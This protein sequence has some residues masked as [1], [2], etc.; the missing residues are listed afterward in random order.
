MTLSVIIPAYNEEKYLPGCLESLVKF[1]GGKFLEIIVV[2]NA[3]RDRTAEVAA[4]FP[5]VR[6]VREGRKGLTHARQRGLLEARGD[7]LAYVDADSR[8]PAEWAGMISRAFAENDRVVCL[9]GPY[10]YYGLPFLQNLCVAF[11]WHALALPV[12]FLTGYMAVGGNFV[13]RRDALE[14]MGGFD[15]SIRFY[16]EDTD[17]ARRLHRI[18][19]VRFSPRFFVYTSARRFEK[20]GML[21]TAWIYVVN[22]V[23]IV[24]FHRPATGEYSDVR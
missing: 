9:S 15:T 22:F 7:L 14:K 17:L 13:A 10:R 11:Y 24:L 5:G 3:S 8:I 12:Y 19:K 6:V 23:W 21:R 18:G 16:G 20:E 1:G 4:R 2:D